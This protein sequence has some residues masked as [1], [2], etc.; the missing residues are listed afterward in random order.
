MKTHP[1]FTLLFWSLFW[2]FHA[3]AQI[4]L[5]IGEE[6]N[7]VIEDLTSQEVK[8]NPEQI[9]YFISCK[10]PRSYNTITRQVLIK[11]DPH[12]YPN[13]K[14]IYEIQEVPVLVKEAYTEI[15]AYPPIFETVEDSVVIQEAYIGEPTFE[16]IREKVEVSPVIV[17]WKVVEGQNASNYYTDE[18]DPESCQVVYYQKTKAEFKEFTRRVPQ[19]QGMTVLVGPITKAKYKKISRKILKEPSNLKAINWPAEYKTEEQKVLVG[20]KSNGKPVPPSYISIDE[21]VFDDSF[22]SLAWED[23]E[24]VDPL[25]EKALYIYIK[26]V[27]QALKTRGYYKGEVNGIIKQTFLNKNAN[28]AIKNFES[29]NEMYPGVVEFVSSATVLTLGLKMVTF[30]INTIPDYKCNTC[31]IKIPN[32]HEEI[33]EEVWEDQIITPSAQEYPNMEP[34]YSTK[35]EHSKINHPA[36]IE[37][38]IEPTVFK[39]IRD[40]VIVQQASKYKGIYQTIDKQVLIRPKTDEW[41]KKSLANDKQTSEISSVSISA[42]PDSVQVHP[43]LENATIV[44]LEKVPA[45]YQTIQQRIL[46]AVKDSH[47]VVNSPAEYH[48]FERDIQLLNARFEFHEVPTIFAKKQKVKVIKGYKNGEEEIPTQSQK[49]LVKKRKFKNRRGTAWQVID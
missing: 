3:K 4:D 43:N 36:S 9:K 31:Y 35:R 8:D 1:I 47:T 46:V 10:P 42:L 24:Y 5:P 28:P 25:R 14:P 11:P 21:E 30:K 26:K 13:L 38:I 7:I 37:A 17:E 18:Q 45:Q 19:S 15:I 33:I 48:Y 49:V 32:Y 39:T 6:I 41:V 23:Y 22:L 44:C 2:N 29:Q 34:V 40:S 27:Q 20:Y 16:N 12:L